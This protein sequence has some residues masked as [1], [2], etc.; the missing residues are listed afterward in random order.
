MAPESVAS[1]LANERGEEGR[2]VTDVID[3]LGFGEAQVRL[4]I[5]GGGINYLNG[6][7]LELMSIIPKSIASDL[8]LH[9]Y[10]RASIYS[11]ALAGKLVGN[12][13]AMGVNTSMGRRTPILLG[14]V[15]ALAAI[16]GSAF[17]YNMYVIA[18]CWFLVGAAVGFAGP[19]WWALCSEACSTNKRMAVNAFSQGLFSIGALCTFGTAFVFDPYLKF[20]AEWRNVILWV[21]VS[22]IVLVLVALFVGFVDSAHAYAARGKIA[23]ASSILEVMRQQN[24]CPDVSIEFDTGGAGAAAESLL[25]VF[26]VGISTMFSQKYCLI[27]IVMFMLTFTLNFA[28]YGVSYAMPLVLTS[29]DLGIS[30]LYILAASEILMV[31]G[32]C[33]ATFL[34]RIFGRR[35]M[36]LGPFLCCGMLAFLVMAYG[37]YQL[38]SAPKGVTPPV[39]TTLVLTAALSFKFVMAHGWLIVYLYATEV[40]PTVCRT[41]AMGLVLGMGRVG[42]LGTAFVFEGLHEHTGSRAIFFGLVCGLMILDGIGAALT[43]PETKG[44]KLEVF[45]KGASE[46]TPLKKT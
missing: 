33:S 16:I 14:Y 45:S 43:L 32:Y 27:T 40:F 9:A 30:P 6:T 1:D 37:L 28:T 4:A 35:V 22:N 20:G 19:N 24:R 12:F 23:E 34:S 31:V 11:A 13:S 29:L 36:I 7:C 3:D 41:S 10:Q 17:G 38:E 44:K 46:N 42:S 25:E 2:T 21:Q 5:L 15:V 18:F 26:Q 39:A 8:G